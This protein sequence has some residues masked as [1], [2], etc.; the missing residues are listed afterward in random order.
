M[1]GSTIDPQ[2]PS[3]SSSQR[4]S[5]EREE[6]PT[7]QEEME[8]ISGDKFWRRSNEPENRGRD[9]EFDEYLADLLL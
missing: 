7:R 2:T 8:P 9:E 5:Q 6:S 4:V 1:R 3:S